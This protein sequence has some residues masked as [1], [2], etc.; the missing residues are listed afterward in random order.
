MMSIL[1]LKRY[2]M[3]S[4]NA[5]EIGDEGII[6]RIYY[7]SMTQRTYSLYEEMK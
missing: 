2:F 5:K 3:T 4:L 6:L 7:K 1:L